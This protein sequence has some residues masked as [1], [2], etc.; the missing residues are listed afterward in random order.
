[1]GRGHERSVIVAAVAGAIGALIGLAFAIAPLGVI[2]AGVAAF[3][4]AVAVMGLSGRK[5]VRRL[6]PSLES[7]FP[8]PKR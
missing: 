5:S 6:D 2:V 4:L 3:G 8:S 1:M 7:R